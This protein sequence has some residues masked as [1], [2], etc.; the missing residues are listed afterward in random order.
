M[1]NNEPPK[2]QDR[3]PGEG[4][5]LTPNHTAARQRAEKSDDDLTRFLGGSPA[6]VF[7]RLLAASLIDIDIAEIRQDQR[8]RP[9][10]RISGGL[11]MMR[12][13]VEIISDGLPNRVWPFALFVK[14]LRMDETLDAAAV[15]GLRQDGII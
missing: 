15:A 4:V 13:P 9:V 10:L 3:P 14:G 7:F 5:I 8:V 2:P 11:P 12:E 6:A 1:S